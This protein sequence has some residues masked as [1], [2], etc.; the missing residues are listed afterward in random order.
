MPAPASSILAGLL[1][2]DAFIQR[3]S[4][5]AVYAGKAVLA[6]AGG[7]VAG[8]LAAP[9]AQERDLRLA[10]AKK[11]IVGGVPPMSVGRVIVLDNTVLSTVTQN[12]SDPNN[13]LTDPVLIAAMQAAFTQMAV[14]GM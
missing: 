10:L 8:D 9:T 4:L 6:A 11:L 1:R 7:Q 14:A 13:S 12:P 2:D 3:I 5:V